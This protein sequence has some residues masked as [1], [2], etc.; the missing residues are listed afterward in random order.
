M[1]GG[2]G[3]K[4]LGASSWLLCHLQSYPHFLPGGSRGLRWSSLT[5]PR[6]P[7]G[8]CLTQFLGPIFPLSST[9]CPD[10]ISLIILTGTGCLPSHRIPQVQKVCLPLI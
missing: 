3:G 7:K 10:E 2:A 6:P 5:I 9:G 1:M 8:K 4:E